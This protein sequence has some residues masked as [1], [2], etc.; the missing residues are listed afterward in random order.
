M[1]CITKHKL[2]STNGVK[3]GVYSCRKIKD[4]KCSK[5]LSVSLCLRQFQPQIRELDLR[6][7]HYPDTYYRR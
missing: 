7:I 6:S 1:K 4:A 5:N 2:S 3:P